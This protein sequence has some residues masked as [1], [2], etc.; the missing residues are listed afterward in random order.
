MGLVQL[1]RTGSIIRWFDQSDEKAG[2]VSISPDG[3]PVLTL[4]VMTRRALL[5]KGVGRGC[6]KDIYRADPRLP[7]GGVR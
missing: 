6:S 1:Y 7:V 2:M 4:S 3:G 5:T